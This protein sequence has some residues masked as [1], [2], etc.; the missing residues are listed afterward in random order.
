MRPL[1]FFVILF[2]AILSAC[3]PKPTIPIT[4]FDS[5][6]AAGNPVMESYPPQCAA[7]GQTF[8]QD[9][10]NELEL[11][12]L[13]QIKTPRPNQ[14]ITSPL[15]ITGSARGTWYFE[16][17]FPLKLVDSSGQIIAE[18]YATA[19]GEWM[20]EDFVPFTAT[21]EFPPEPPGTQTTLILEKSN[22][23]GLPEHAQELRVPVNLTP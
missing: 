4:D 21:L 3:A 11:T 6:V 14:T 23:S 15:E 10:G 19:Q 17:T 20:T 1:N 7:N 22:P 5:C 8:T 12:D 2:A 13:I 18:S 9:I 16:A